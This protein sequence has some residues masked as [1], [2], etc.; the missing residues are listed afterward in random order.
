MM[1]KAPRIRAATLREAPRKPS[2]ERKAVPIMPKKKRRRT[3][4]SITTVTRG[5]HVLRWVENTPE[6][7]K[8][9]S[10]TFYGTYKEASAELARIRVRV[11]DDAPVPTLGQVYEMWWRPSIDERVD[12]GSLAPNTH[13]NYVRTWERACAPTW[14][15]T[16]VDS[17]RPLDVQRWLDGMTNGNAL[18]AMSVMKQLAEVAVKYEAC[19]S[20][21][22]KLKYAMPSRKAKPRSRDVYD[23][24][25][26]D[27]MM[28]AV[29]G[30]RI[31][32]A[33]IL[34][35]FGSCRTGEAL[36][37]RADMV[38]GVESHGLRLALAAV[39]DQMA[40]DATLSGRVKN[41]Q[42][43][44]TVVVPPP[45]SLRLLE[46]AGERLES[47]TRWLCDAGDGAP[48]GKRQLHREWSKAA[49]SDRIPFANLRNSWRTFAQAEWGVDYDL[50]EVLMGHV[51]PGV[52]GRH[53][54]R[55]SE[56]QIVDQFAA[57]YAN[58]MRS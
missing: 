22:F 35:A 11:G 54:L 32:A 30:F 58:F 23:L 13:G 48:M 4:G 51:L 28:G 53:Y 15:N 31:E 57:A 43:A 34:A 8:R 44:R 47:G 38:R 19:D 21:K 27:A 45:Y 42:S 55:M 40:D 14:A 9:R 2:I 46:I 1:Q 16:P 29:R 56:A 12:A 18:I 20:N 3:W 25:K 49:G 5:K 24:A 10:L 39:D 52:T 33:Y 41:E 17:V 26:A 6:G 7:R 37:V 50:L 36:A